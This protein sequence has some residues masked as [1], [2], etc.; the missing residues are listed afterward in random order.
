[1]RMCSRRLVRVM[2]RVGPAELTLRVM[3][4]GPAWR[5]LWCSGSA[6]SALCCLHTPVTPPIPATSGYSHLGADD[7]GHTWWVVLGVDTVSSR[8]PRQTP[9]GRSGR[10]APVIPRAP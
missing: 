2:E 6:P 3:P 1:M 9:P 10:H 4:P 7:R 5:E 8:L